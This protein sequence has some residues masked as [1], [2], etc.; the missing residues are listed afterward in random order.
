MAD[1]DG[2]KMS[3]GKGADEV[4]IIERPLFEMIMKRYEDG[5]KGN[6]EEAECLDLTLLGGGQVNPIIR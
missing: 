1:A 6:R 4:L 2:K 3:P 5:M